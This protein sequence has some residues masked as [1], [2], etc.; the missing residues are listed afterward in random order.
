MTEAIQTRAAAARGGDQYLD[1]RRLAERFEVP[2]AFLVCERRN[3]VRLWR[4]SG[5]PC[6]II[7]VGVSGVCFANLGPRLSPGDLVRLN[8]HFPR[9]TGIRVKAQIVRIDALPTVI[10]QQ[11]GAT[12]TDLDAS[13][14]RALCDL[15]STHSNT[16]AIVSRTRLKEEKSIP[17]IS[18]LIKALS[19][20]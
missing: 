6:H 14:W 13:G 20:R 15:Y 18:R 11:C 1:R 3:F 16:A 4:I 7:N 9:K 10:G 19:A 8:L 5:G 17:N 2:D 12:F